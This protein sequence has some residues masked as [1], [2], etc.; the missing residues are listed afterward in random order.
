MLQFPRHD[1]IKDVE[2]W[3]S[4]PPVDAFKASLRRRTNGALQ[5]AA[6]AVP[7]ELG[8]RVSVA[9]ADVKP[10]TAGFHGNM[11]APMCFVNS[12]FNARAL[13]WS[14][15]WAHVFS[16]IFE[17]VL[18]R[19]AFS[20]NVLVSNFGDVC[21]KSMTLLHVYTRAELD[22]LTMGEHWV[23]FR[24]THGRLLG[25]MHVKDG[26]E[27]VAGTE[28]PSCVMSNFVAWSVPH[29]L[30][31][32]TWASTS[33]QHR[34]YDRPAFIARPRPPTDADVDL[35]WWRAFDNNDLTPGILKQWAYEGIPVRRRAAD[36]VGV[37]SD[38]RLSFASHHFT[39]DELCRA[40]WYSW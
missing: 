25:R 2:V 6:G 39:F 28:A 24:D 1:R 15:K 12:C 20:D 36:P 27:D 38:G 35:Y 13:M 18:A 5:T 8:I 16:D 11:H 23:E 30:N 29:V 3:E 10:H 37:A 26:F 21:A 9:S 33:L 19:V 31:L 17:V 34:L 22:S 32:C 14:P 4:A 7:V 40:S